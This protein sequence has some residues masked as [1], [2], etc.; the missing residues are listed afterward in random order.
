MRF[1]HLA[2]KLYGRP[3]LLHP[4]VLSTFGRQLAIRIQGQPLPP[5][6]SRVDPA[7]AARV[8][9]P[10][11]RLTSGRVQDICQQAGPVA[12]ITV[13]GVIDKA[14]SNADMDC[15]GGCDLRDVDAA[16]AA[17]AAD[18]SVSH[19][20]LHLDTPGGGVTGVP[21]SAARIR[22][23]AQ[24]K[25]VHVFCDTQCCSAGMWLAAGADVIAAAPSA[26]VGSIGVYFCIM[27]ES[28]ALAEEGIS[29]Q[30]IQAGDLK[31][32]GSSLRPMTAEEAAMFQAEAD[33]LYAQFTAAVTASRAVPPAAMRGQWYAAGEGLGFKVID[34]LTQASLD[35][36]VSALLED[37]D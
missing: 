30:I 23:L 9:A 19:V 16:L 20:V 14:I 11:A 37:L 15:Y 1:P 12:V 32:M 22:A 25:E 7:P 26:L 28:A 17:A 33:R 24:D 2:A 18:P 31:G 27:D 3:L 34:V 6:Q 29:V 13:S 21:E 4:P 8:V 35:E 10:F 36:Y 5:A